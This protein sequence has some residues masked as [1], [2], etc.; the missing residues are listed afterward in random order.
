M[1]THVPPH[2]GTSECSSCEGEGRVEFAGT[3]GFWYRDGEQY[4][5]PGWEICEACNGTGRVS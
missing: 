3:P 1:T 5:P 2:D 4:D